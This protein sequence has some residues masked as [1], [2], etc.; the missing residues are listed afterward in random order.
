MVQAEILVQLDQKRVAESLALLGRAQQLVPSTQAY[1]KRLGNYLRKVGREA[2]AQEA[3][4]RADAVKAEK[5]L[6]FFLLGEQYQRDDKFPEAIREFENAL[7]KDHNHYG[8]HF[9]LA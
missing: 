9:F 5:A 3:H 4:R 6:D 8:A 7:E 1:F 2:E